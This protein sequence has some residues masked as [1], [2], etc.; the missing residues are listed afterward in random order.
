[1]ADLSPRGLVDLEDS[2]KRG[3]LQRRGGSPQVSSAC[4]ARKTG[5]VRCKRDGGSSLHRWVIGR[6]SSWSL[7]RV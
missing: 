7:A 2:I 6:L 4:L 5:T 1:M 3:S